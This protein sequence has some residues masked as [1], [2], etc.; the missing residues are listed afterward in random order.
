MSRKTEAYIKSSAA[1][2]IAGGLAFMAVNTLS[3]HTMKRRST[4]KVF[5]MLGSLMEAI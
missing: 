3:R 5:K 2:L 4:A 1:G